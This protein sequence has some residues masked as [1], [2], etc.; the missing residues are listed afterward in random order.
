MLAGACTVWVIMDIPGTTAIVQV[1]SGGS[2]TGAAYIES[3]LADISGVFDKQ[4]EQNHAEAA[5]SLLLAMVPHRKDTTQEIQILNQ[6]A[7]IT[8]KHKLDPDP[9]S[10]QYATLGDKL[11]MLHNASEAEAAYRQWALL[12]SPGLRRLLADNMRKKAETYCQTDRTSAEICWLRQLA[13]LDAMPTAKPDRETIDTLASLGWMYRDQRRFD[14]AARIYQEET[15]ATSAADPMDQGILQLDLAWLN[16]DQAKYKDA[17][18]AYLRAAELF[19]KAGNHFWEGL[20][21]AKTS[22]S[23]FDQHEFDKSEKFAT[24]GLELMMAN[25]S[26]GNFGWRTAYYVPEAIFSCGNVFYHNDRKDQLVNAFAQGLQFLDTHGLGD[27]HFSA[28][29]LSRYIQALQNCGRRA[30]AQAL[31]KRLDGMRN[32]PHR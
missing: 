5:R 13:L 15:A 11:V 25:Q 14:D 24:R 8:T 16:T 1:L 19:T 23:L 27:S 30:E 26:Q 7:A 18:R 3:T 4:I 6:V 10:K 12:T 21:Y 22:S 17:D 2:P 31:Q 20:T 9:L 28:T 32:T 29:Y